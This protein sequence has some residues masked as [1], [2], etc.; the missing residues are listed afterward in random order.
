MLFGVVIGV[1]IF[2]GL[3]IVFFKL[4][5]CMSGV[6]IILLVCY[7]I[8]IVLVVVLVFFIVCLVFIG[9]VF[10]FWMIIILVLVFGVFMIILMYMW[11]CGS[12]LL[13]EKF[14]KFEFLFVDFV[15]MLEKWLL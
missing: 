7:I 10:D 1:L 9:G 6:L 12:W 4:F 3:V 8:N 11:W 13:F 5:V 14:C 2:I 15:V